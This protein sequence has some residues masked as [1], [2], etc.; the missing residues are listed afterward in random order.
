MHRCSHPMHNFSTGTKISQD[1][2]ISFI[3]PQFLRLYS[4]RLPRCTSFVQLQLRKSLTIFSMLAVRSLKFE[5][6]LRVRSDQEPLFVHENQGGMEPSPV[7]RINLVFGAAVSFLV[8]V[9]QSVVQDHP[10]VA[11][12]TVHTKG[13]QNRLEYWRSG[14]L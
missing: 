11:I 1:L 6:S 3:F 5:Q 2:H 8:E 7:V 10:H 9:Q 12:H 4:G 14:F 13:R